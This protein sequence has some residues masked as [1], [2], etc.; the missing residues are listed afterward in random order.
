[1]HIKDI[2][3]RGA[4]NP[5]FLQILPDLTKYFPDFRHYNVKRA[6]R[7]ASLDTQLVF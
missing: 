7:Y 1:M 4:Q 6:L 3:Q 2:A 5:F